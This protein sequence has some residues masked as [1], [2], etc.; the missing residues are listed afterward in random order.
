MRRALP[1]ALWLVMAFG[2]AATARASGQWYDAPVS[3]V[4]PS[5][6][7]ETPGVITGLRL[8]QKPPLIE[9]TTEKGEALA[10][11][12]PKWA[13][14]SVKGKLARLGYLKNGQR[15]ILMW[16]VLDDKRVVGSLDIIPPE[17]PKPLPPVSKIQRPAVPRLDWAIPVQPVPAPA[18]AAAPRP[19]MPVAPSTQ[20][21]RR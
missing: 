20:D 14:I 10:L 6:Y 19:I 2:I 16:T 21:L 13:L 4:D 3:P 11:I 18:P 15:G 1:A 5:T 9:F 8:D 7:D 17:P 12:I